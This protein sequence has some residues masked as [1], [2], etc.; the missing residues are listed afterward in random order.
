MDTIPR[1]F[2]S[3]MHI[4]RAIDADLPTIESWLHHYESVEPFSTF[5]QNWEVTLESHF[6]GNLMVYVDPVLT[7]PVAYH[8][9]HLVHGGILEVRPDM[10]G[11]GIGNALV[12][13]ALALAALEDEPIL[14]VQ[15]A[16]VTS[17]GFWQRMGFTVLSPNSQ[18]HVLGYRVLQ[19]LEPLEPQGI[20]AD[21]L[22]EWSSPSNLK[23]SSSLIQP[24]CGVVDEDMV[25]LAERV[26]CPSMVC[27]RP[28][29]RVTVNEAIWYEGN[30]AGFDAEYA[31]IISCLNGKYLDY[32]TRT[33][34]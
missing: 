25:Y 10:R 13:H 32:L 24:V 16:P 7:Q 33:A 20:H 11:R 5:L 12:Q 15:C 8:W 34:A 28:D 2:P 9:G 21:V 19:R 30:S 31:G 23:G 18:G 17:T 29:V 22:V 14:R 4:R 26:A 6:E 3:N 1:Y 27:R